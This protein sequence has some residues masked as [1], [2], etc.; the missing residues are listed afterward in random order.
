VDPSVSYR[1]QQMGNNLLV[2]TTHMLKVSP[3][4]GVRDVART[5]LLEPFV[6]VLQSS[7]N[8]EERILATFAL[9]SFINDS[10]GFK[11][12]GAYVKGICKPLKQLRKFSSATAD[13][14]RSVFNL[15]FVNISSF[16]V[17]QN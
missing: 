2:T 1:D 5:C 3:D 4:T 6:M 15:P 10:E 8:L 11:D 9:S 17:L 12:L 14:L 16:A 13:I 7:K